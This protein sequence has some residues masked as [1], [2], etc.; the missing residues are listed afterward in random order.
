MGAVTTL[1]LHQ[2]GELTVHGAG[3]LAARI[4]S[5]VDRK[6]R[7]AILYTKYGNHKQAY[8]VVRSVD[9]S[10]GS[11]HVSPSLLVDSL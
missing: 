1:C 9:E 4:T 10:D 6:H 11:R 3:H 2:L 5:P 7:C 8:G